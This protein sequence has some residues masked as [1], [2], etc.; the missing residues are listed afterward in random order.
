MTAIFLFIRMTRNE[1]NIDETAGLLIGHR[2][3]SKLV[4]SSNDVLKQI[5]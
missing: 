1:K 5:W 3:T 4:K 2:T